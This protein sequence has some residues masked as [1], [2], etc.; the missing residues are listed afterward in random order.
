MGLPQWS[1]WSFITSIHIFIASNSPNVPP[2][3][4]WWAHY[5]LSK[6]IKISQLSDSN[7]T[8][9]FVEYKPH[10]ISTHHPIDVNDCLQSPLIGLCTSHTHCTTIT[11]DRVFL[12]SLF[13][14]ANFADAFFISNCIDCVYKV[15]WVF[16]CSVWSV[17][18]DLTFGDETLGQWLSQTACMFNSTLWRIVNWLVARAWT[19]VCPWKCCEI[20]GKIISWKSFH[21]PFTRT[22]IEWILTKIN[23]RLCVC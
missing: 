4:I 6:I 2:T 21:R 10:S 17:R 14:Y 20:N 12:F 16:A 19:D 15:K 13:I 9:S 23:I 5:C 11:V 8:A 18:L 1:I 22:R 3:A 7:W